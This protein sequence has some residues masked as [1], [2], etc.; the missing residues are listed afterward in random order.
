[1]DNQ[2]TDICLQRI[3]PCQNM[4]RFYATALQPNLFGGHSLIRT[5]GR[6]GTVG[7]TKI[8]LFSSNEEAESARNHLVRTKI[9]RGYQ[10]TSNTTRSQPL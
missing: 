3:D 5:W 4:F 10:L 9:S 8:E 7:T 6:I 2:A 1:M